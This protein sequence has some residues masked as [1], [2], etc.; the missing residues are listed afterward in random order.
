MCIRD[1]S[2]SLRQLDACR[3]KTKTQ[4]STQPI[5]RPG[6]MRGV[7]KSAA[8]CQKQGG[9]ACWITLH[10]SPT[11]S[12][13]PFEISSANLLFQQLPAYRSLKVSL[14]ENL[15]EIDACRPGGATPLPPLAARIPPDRPVLTTL[16]PH[17]AS[18][19]AVQLFGRG[20]WALLGPKPQNYTLPGALL[21]PKPQIFTLPGTPPRPLKA[22]IKIIKKTRVLPS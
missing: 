13:S 5:E 22:K 3:P 15:L 19:I 12:Q 9:R 7:I 8:P 6:G 2:R 21:G 4:H 11:P 16:P 1:S 20:P 18:K 17:F 10:N 14:I